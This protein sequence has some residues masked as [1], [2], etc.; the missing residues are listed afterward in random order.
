MRFLLIFLFPAAMI[1]CNNTAKNKKDL[2]DGE[3][4][5]KDTVKQEKQ[6]PGTTETDTG[7]TGLGTEPFWS[8]Y[9]IVNSKILFHPANGPAV[10]VPYTVP[11][12]V[13]N[14]VSV[15]SST[16]G[17]ASIK[18]IITKKD[19]ND[20]MSEVTYPYSVTLSVNKI[21]YA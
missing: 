9:V 21:K 8:V 14:T 16:A 19:C 6:M 10:E 2:P 20:G 18:L 15:Y 11:S 17:P 5:A 3:T 4:A 1:A 7:F 13:S 12:A